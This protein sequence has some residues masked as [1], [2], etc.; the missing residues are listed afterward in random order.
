MGEPSTSPDKG[1]DTSSK[2][3]RSPASIKPVKKKIGE[4][5]DNLRR[6]AEWYQRRTGGRARPRST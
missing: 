1:H 5:R 4:P 2:P 3:G 6:R